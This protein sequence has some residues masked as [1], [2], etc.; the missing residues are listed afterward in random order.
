MK[1]LILGIVLGVIS[2][3]VAAYFY[4]AVETTWLMWAGTIIFAVLGVILI[5]WG[6]MAGMKKGGGTPPPAAP[7]S[8]PSQPTPPPAAPSEPQTPQTPPGAPM[9]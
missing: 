6:V 7:P 4:V 8:E 3:V 5:I 2:L 9:Q 1:N